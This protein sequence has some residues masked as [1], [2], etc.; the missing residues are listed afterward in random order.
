MLHAEEFLILKNAELLQEVI[1]LKS[2]KH[3]IVG[4]YEYE[5]YSIDNI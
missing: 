5:Q 3:A 4:S 2:K 1:T